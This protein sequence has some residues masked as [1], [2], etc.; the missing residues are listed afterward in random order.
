MTVDSSTWRTLRQVLLG[1]T[2]E[3]EA[4][5]RELAQAAVQGS[6]LRLTLD[7]APGLEQWVS[8]ELEKVIFQ[9]M[10]L[11]R[12]SHDLAIAL[13]DLE[14]SALRLKGSA[15]AHMLF[16][17]PGLR[18]RR[19][20]DLL[21]TP[22]TRTL[23]IERLQQAGWSRLPDNERPWWSERVEGR[24]EETMV[25]DFG[26]QRVE[27]DLH[28]RLSLYRHLGG[29]SESLLGRSHR[30]DGVS[31]RLPSLEDLALHTA[32]HAASTGFRVP[33]KSWF[34]LHLLSMQSELDWNLLLE[35]ADTWNIPTALWSALSVIVRL[36]G[37]EI[38]AG[39]LDR[40][41]PARPLRSSL[42]RLLCGDGETPIPSAPFEEARRQAAKSLALGGTKPWE[43]VLEQTRI[44]LEQP[45]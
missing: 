4:C 2:I 31:F 36:F 34:D 11:E 21:L 45:E 33:L 20:I 44:R 37:T 13:G 24:Y 30:Q 6:V 35:E 7:K 26:G 42:M 38:P 17:E 5:S 15:S 32:L 16:A 3:P 19:D 10:L 28:F 39:V 8:N 41:E 22:E 29:N 9:D 40:L 23:V 12:A 25:K 43:L 14:D 1:E 18:E 27:A